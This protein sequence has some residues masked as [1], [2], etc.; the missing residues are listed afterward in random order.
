MG[1]MFVSWLMEMGDEPMI[2]E[3]RMSTAKRRSHGSL[4]Y[5]RPI[6]TSFIGRE[7]IRRRLAASL[8]AQK[9]RFDATQARLQCT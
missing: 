3:C 9:R 1:Q 2:E 6:G 8:A 7:T 5:S 4:R